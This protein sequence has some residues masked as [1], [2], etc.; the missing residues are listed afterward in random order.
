MRCLI[1]DDDNSTRV[2]LQAYLC[3]VAVC[4]VANDGYEAIEAVQTSLEMSNPYDLICIDLMM[5]NMDGYDTIKV[6]R[7]LEREYSSKG[8]QA[9]IIVITALNLA[10]EKEA[11]IAQGCLDFLVKPVVKTKLLKVLKNLG[12]IESNRGFKK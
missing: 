9:K 1:V 7:H 6:I 5:P 3:D 8:F 2:M 11:L 10:E 12:L 4:N